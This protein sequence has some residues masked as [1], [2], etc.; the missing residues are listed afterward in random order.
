VNNQ[1]KS[2]ANKMDIKKL[3]QILL[4]VGGVIIVIAIIWWASFYGGVTEE[5]GGN[6]GDA[7]KCLFS[8]GGECGFVSGL[9]QFAGVTPYNPIVF[10]IG[11]VILGVGLILKFSLKEK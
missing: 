4:A 8:S 3:T 1:R 9:A 6:L 11:V 7:F 10:W 5:I 2:E